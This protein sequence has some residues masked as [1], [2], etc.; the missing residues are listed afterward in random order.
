MIPIATS[1]SPANRTPTAGTIP[2]FRVWGVPVRLHFTFVLLVVFVT[3]QVIGSTNTSSGFATFLVGSLISVLLH[4]LGHAAMAS[5]FGVR[6]VEIVMFPIGGLARMER[7]LRP[8]AEV[9]VALAGPV[10]NLMLAGGI[11]AF[12]L[13]NKELVPIR[14]IDFLQPG[15][16]SVPALLLYGNILLA[17]FNLL[18]AFPMD[19]GRILRALLS[20]IRPEQEAT[21]TAAWMGRMLAIGMGL[22]GLVAA[23]FLVVFFALFIYLGAAQESV[24]ALGRTLAHGIP[25]RAAM[26][27]EFRTLDHGNTVRDAANLMLSTSQ[28]DFPIVHGGK[29]V[30]L[31]DRKS[32]LRSI[33]TEGPETYVAGAMDREF[34]SVSPDA[35]L[36]QVLPQMAHAGHCAL[37]M[38]NDRLLGIL[39]TDNLSEFLLL[40]RIGMEPAL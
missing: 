39:T 4:E 1:T 12:M 38:E 31:L 10:I 28:Q 37:V 9:M 40:R 34:E 18:P 32:L 14:P 36:A 16:K 6:T 8:A 33:A 19:G 27:T 26:I 2:V 22:Y 29:V 23:Q 7:P 17:F 30:G 35:D 21:R 15:G 20:F 5:H 25:V 13:Q 3:V 24:A 11:F